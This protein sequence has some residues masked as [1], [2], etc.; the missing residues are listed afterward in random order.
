VGIFIFIDLIITKHNVRLDLTPTKKFTLSPQ[1]KK[2]LKELKKDINIINFYKAGERAET[3]DILEF[4]SLECPR[5]K[6][7]MVNLDRNPGLAKKYKISSY[8]TAVIICGDKKT[9]IPYPS[10]ERVLNSILKVTR[11]KK[12]KIYFLIGHGENDI[13]SSGANR[14]YSYIKEQ[15]ETEYYEVENLLLMG[16]KKIPEDASLLVISGP[17][18]DLFPFEFDYIKK[19]LEDG[20]KVLF[21]LDPHVTSKFA[22][23]FKKYNIILKDDII[24]DKENRLFGSD[25]KMPIISDFTKHDVT[26]PFYGSKI[27]FV[28]ALARSV[29]I[30][31]PSE[32][33]ENFEIKLEELLKTSK[34]SWAELDKKSLEDN[35]ITF[36]SDK[37][38]KGPVTVGV[39]AKL[40]MDTKD[41]KE[42]KREGRFVVYGDSDF[43]NNF[44]WEILGNRDLFLNTINWLTEEEALISVREKKQSPMPKLSPFFLTSIQKRIIFFVTIILMPLIFLTIGVLIYMQRKFY[45]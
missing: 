31:E 35:K 24:I 33:K 27:T 6:Y 23:F 5:I 40:I 22:S 19:Y 37:D 29:L 16:K 18:R 10:E 38:I 21:M 28:F 3:E 41:K 30:M 17:E 25:E 9:N 34:F 43:A 8:G 1:T 12:D 7:K 20:G 45:N 11:N 42:R 14:G 32:K 13:K 2:V 26:R 36:D 15:L 39:A 44:Y 4:F